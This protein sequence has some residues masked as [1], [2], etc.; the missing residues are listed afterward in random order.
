MRLRLELV[1][2]H[3]VDGDLIMVVLNLFVMTGI[4]ASGIAQVDVG[5]LLGSVEFRV[6]QR[7]FSSKVDQASAIA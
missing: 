7:L 5:S 3:L 4:G 6:D 2:E 1:L